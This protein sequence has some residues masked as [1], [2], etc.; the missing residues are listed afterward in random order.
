MG[1][2]TALRL[3]KEHGAWGMLYVPLLL[4]ALVAGTGAGRVAFL[5]LSATLFFIGRESFLGWW[6]ARSRGRDAGSAPKVAFLYLGLSAV[7]AAPLVLYSALT[8]LIPLGLIAAAL[9]LWNAQ[10]AARR[11]ERT[12]FTELVG[13]AGLTLTAPAAHYVAAGRWEST[14]VWLWA[15]SAVYFASSVFYVRLRVLTAYPKNP[16]ELV[17]IRRW[18]GLF[19]AGLALCLVIVVLGGQLHWLIFAAY[20]PVVTRAFRHLV[21]PARELVLR[22]VGVLEIV[23]SVVFLVFAVLAFRLSV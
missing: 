19:H 22:R 12:M 7:V 14:A 20:L 3:P 23:Y 21:R 8:G 5:A 9:L 1:L 2:R 16:E 17:H 15:L 11:E 6:R 10:Q 18:C 4:G 13:I